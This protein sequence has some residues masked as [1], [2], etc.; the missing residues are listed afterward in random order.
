MSN[1]LDAYNYAMQAKRSA[2]QQVLASGLFGQVFGDLSDVGP[3]G[4]TGTSGPVCPGA[5]GVATQNKL[6][7]LTEEEE[8]P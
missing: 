4:I 3:L 8:L 6:L 2:Q 5:V 1:S 7:L